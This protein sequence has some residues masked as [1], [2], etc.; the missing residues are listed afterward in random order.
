MAE[1]VV[2]QHLQDCFVYLA[3][4]DT[5]FLQIARNSVK[6]KYFSSEIIENII[7][8][9]YFYYDLT[10]EAPKDHLHDEL[11]RFLQDKS[12]DQKELYLS[13]LEKIQRMDPP[14]KDYIISR[15]NKFIQAREFEGAAIKFVRLVEQ[16]KF[17]EGRQLMQHALRAG[18]VQEEVGIKYLEEETPVY[19]NEEVSGRK[20]III[21]TGFS[22]IDNVIKGFR[23]KEFVCVFAGYKVGKT[24]AGVH[25]GT[26]GLLH[27][28]KVL[29]ISHEESAEN[30]DMR[31]DMNLGS[32]VSSEHPEVI[33]FCE[34][35]SEGQPIRTYELERDT[36]FDL[37]NIRKIRKKI[38]RFGGRLIIKK[39]PMGACTIGEVERYLDYLETYEG[40][41]PDVLINDY[42]EKMKLLPESDQRRDRIN[43]AYID[44]KRIADERNIVVITASQ[45][46][47]Q[48]LERK[49]VSQ[50][51]SA[52]E[53]MRKLGNV[54]VGLLLSQ[55][56]AQERN[57]RMQVF[58]LVNRSGEQSFGCVV[59]KNLRVG[60]L[61]LQSWPLRLGEDHEDS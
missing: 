52:A 33:S 18:I 61:A 7:R 10:K 15:I 23:R 38:T 40:F 31:Y 17:Q 20:G 26:L 56:R 55:T 6:E 49:I 53:D 16:G 19:Y 2:N 35:N 41:T 58:V 51:E 21:P 47:G 45:I 27:G 48:S 11:V 9:C 60:Q 25:F 34:Y 54:D 1:T 36:V 29:H 22:V 30:L 5:K 4:T 42:I 24:W 13:Y 50:R 32:F 28:R 59:S 8:L 14:N 57:N 43:Q 3:I 12:D 46:K 39:Y 44:H 37:D